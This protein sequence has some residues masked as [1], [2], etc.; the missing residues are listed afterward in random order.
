MSEVKKYDEETNIEENIQNGKFIDPKFKTEE[1][2]IF[3]DLNENE[4]IKY[5]KEYLNMNPELKISWERIFDSQNK[6]TVEEKEDKLNVT[7][8]ILSNC[9]FIS[10]IHNLKQ[11]EPNIFYSI[12]KEC[13]MKKGYFE[14]YFYFEENGN[15]V[16]KS[17]FV[18]DFIPYKK[19]PD[20]Y[21]SLYKPLFSNYMKY[22]EEIPEEEFIQYSVGKY[23]LI[24]KAYAKI[25]GGYLN[26]IGSKTK[27]DIGLLLTGVRRKIKYLSSFLISQTKKKG[28]NKYEDKDDDKEEIR[29]NIK[30][31]IINENILNN[32]DKTV[33]FENIQ[34]FSKENLFTLDTAKKPISKVDINKY[35]I[36]S[37]HSYDFISCEKNKENLFFSIWNPHGCNFMSDNNK[38]EGFDE[39]NEKNNKGKFNGDIILNFD[40]FFLS[41]LKIRYINRDE[42]RKIHNKYQSEDILDLLGITLYEKLMIF[43]KFGE[44]FDFVITLL[45]SR[46]Y[47]NATKIKRN[48]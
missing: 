29:Y 46:I 16:K 33:I 3:G 23:L 13:D 45:L 27:Y 20:Y 8:G 37:D 28:I 5:K 30:N 39:I 31:E 7:Q 11:N 9:Y 2:S 34:N 35:G 41:F 36:W 12:I 14:V 25:A 43:Y 32:D 44:H 17:I 26:I 19:L 47:S 10:F 21:K 4:I 40:R 18:D 42:V 22:M 48:F 38:Y 1:K 24:E 6:F 15:I